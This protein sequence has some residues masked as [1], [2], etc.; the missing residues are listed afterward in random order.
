MKYLIGQ[1]AYGKQIG[2]CSRHKYIYAK[3]IDC[4][5]VRWINYYTYYLKGKSKR[6]ASCSK[7]NRLSNV[8]KG[9]R[10]IREGYA[11]VRVYPKDEYYSM[12]SGNG[13]VP[14]HRLVMAKSV[15]RPLARKEV[16]H[17]IN[18]EKTDNRIENLR[19]MESSK[20]HNT[21]YSGAYKEGYAE[22]YKAGLCLR[23]VAHAS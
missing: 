2:K 3:C 13:Y 10:T 15:G 16:V 23:G 19:L 5:K 11:I 4:E 14:E 20:F 9:G 7:I 6:C 21:N 22:G 8:W 17:H 1:I 18:G 12:A